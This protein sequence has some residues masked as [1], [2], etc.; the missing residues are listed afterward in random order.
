MKALKP[1]DSAREPERLFS[2]LPG[3]GPKLAEE[4]RDRLG[5]RTLQELHRA[6]QQGRL[7]E[8]GVGA[9]RLTGIMAALEK[10]LAP[11]AVPVNEPA[12]EDLLAVDRDYLAG[13]EVDDLPR[14]APRRFNPEGEAWLGIHR[15]ERKGWK[16]KALFSNTA[17]AHRLERHR[18]WVVVYFE[19]GDIRGQRT[20]VTET[21][22]DMAGRR[23]VRGREGEC[24][25]FYEV[26]PATNEPAA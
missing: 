18:D 3:V 15:A 20:I 7:A 1:A 17:L 26:P 12:L 16:L 4:L 5:L 21:R 23:V 24:R 10:R 6:A 13:M 22:G 25:A 11:P 14:L 19:K 8:V 2:T 9:K